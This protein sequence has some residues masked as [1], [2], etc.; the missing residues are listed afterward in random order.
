MMAEPNCRSILP[1]IFVPDVTGDTFRNEH[2][3]IIDPC[4]CHAK[5]LKDTRVQDIG[6]RLLCDCL[7]NKT[8]QKIPAVA[9]AMFSPRSKIQNGS[10]KEFKHVL[11]A[12]LLSHQIRVAPIVCHPVTRNPSSMGQEMPSSN[13]APTRRD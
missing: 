13:G 1:S 3:S 5:K 6:K 9:V 2:L 7:N 12:V 10:C 8:K 11:T 4:L